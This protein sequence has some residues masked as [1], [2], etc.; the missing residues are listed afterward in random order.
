MLSFWHNVRNVHTIKLLQLMF[1]S[2]KR[3]SCSGVLD[4]SVVEIAR[5]PSPGEKNNLTQK[6]TTSRQ[7]SPPASPPT[8]NNLT[9]VNT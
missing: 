4:G 2:G 5:T 6:S 3:A 7:N 8:G 9:A 1:I